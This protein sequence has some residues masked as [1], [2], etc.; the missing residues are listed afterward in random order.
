MLVLDVV[1]GKMTCIEVLDRD[2]IRQQLDGILPV[3]EILHAQSFC[4][5]MSDAN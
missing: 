1:Y 5:K 3:D 2:D 4:A